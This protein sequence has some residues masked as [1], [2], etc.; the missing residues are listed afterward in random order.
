[1]FGVVLLQG[2]GLKWSLMIV[3]VGYVILAGMI[4]WKERSRPA[5]EA[6]SPRP[7]PPPGARETLRSRRLA[8]GPAG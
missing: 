8:P 7:S 4:E 3:A 6:S 5:N 2:I 1:L